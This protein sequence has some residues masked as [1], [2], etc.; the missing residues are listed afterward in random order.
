MTGITKIKNPWQPEKQILLI[1]G[2]RGI[3][4]WGA[5]ETFKKWYDDIYKRKKGWLD[6]SRKHGSFSAL[7]EVHYR[8]SDIIKTELLGIIDIED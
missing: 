4:S 1:A 2:V 5:A 8:N 7:L 6:K 3:G